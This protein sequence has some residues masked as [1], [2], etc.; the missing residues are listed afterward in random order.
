MTMTIGAS[1]AEPSRW[2]AHPVGSFFA[3]AAALVL[4]LLVSFVVAVVVGAMLPHPSS[5]LGRILW[6]AAIFVVS[7]AIF[8]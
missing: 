3:S 7:G 2:Q 4:P 1:S 6:W 8:V 5:L